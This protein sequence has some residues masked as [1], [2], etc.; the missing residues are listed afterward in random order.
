MPNWYLFNNWGK[1]TRQPHFIEMIPQL[2][3][4]GFS[5]FFYLI[6]ISIL[7]SLPSKKF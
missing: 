1:N 5:S 4:I 3:F 6:K 7:I 2:V